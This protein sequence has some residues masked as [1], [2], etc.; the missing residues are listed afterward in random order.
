MH[1][2]RMKAERDRE[3]N[4]IRNK[5]EN[6]FKL[7]SFEEEKSDAVGDEEL[8]LQMVKRILLDKEK[9][10]LNKLEISQTGP[11]E[12]TVL[13]NSQEDALKNIKMIRENL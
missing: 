11:M 13:K 9:E 2:Q 1:Q 10:L 3:M 6:I 4:F 8:A 5:L 12:T 7:P